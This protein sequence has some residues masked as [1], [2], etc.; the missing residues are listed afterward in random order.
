MRGYGCDGSKYVRMRIGFIV[1][2]NEIWGRVFVGFYYFCNVLVY[3]RSKVR[4]FIVESLFW[5]FRVYIFF[6]Y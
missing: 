2:V 3:R 5:G 6:C 1:R 4:W